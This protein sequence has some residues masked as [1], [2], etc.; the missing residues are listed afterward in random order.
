MNKQR[1]CFT[2][3]RPEKLNISERNVIELFPHTTEQM[4]EQKI[5]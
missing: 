2:G 1:V 4:A 5:Q 3:H